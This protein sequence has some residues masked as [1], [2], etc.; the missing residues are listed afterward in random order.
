M[1]NLVTPFHKI[2]CFVVLREFIYYVFPRDATGLSAVCE[3]GIS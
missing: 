2:E 1:V 3:C